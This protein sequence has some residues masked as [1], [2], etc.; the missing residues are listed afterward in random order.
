MAVEIG[1]LNSSLADKK[2]LVFNALQAEQLEDANL[3]IY[4]EGNLIAFV[5]SCPQLILP[6]PEKKCAECKGL[7]YE[8]DGLE[9]LIIEK[10][11]LQ[12]TGRNY[13]QIQHLYFHR[14]HF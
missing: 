10:R 3:H 5:F 8:N 13:D 14:Y 4:R 12:G 2:Y 7:I 1:K 11:I 6:C 9:L